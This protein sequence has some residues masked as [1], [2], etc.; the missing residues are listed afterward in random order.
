MVNTLEIKEIKQM[1]QA[2]AEC[3]NE[4]NALDIFNDLIKAVGVINQVQLL[5]IL[6]NTAHDFAMMHNLCP[7]CAVDLVDDTIQE[8]TE[9]QG[10]TKYI[11]IPVKRCPDCMKLY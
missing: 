11:D 9:Y 1:L 4:Q 7:E 10:E 5:T 2:L 3:T 8:P 6:R